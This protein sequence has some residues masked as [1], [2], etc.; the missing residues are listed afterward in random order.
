[1]DS[2]FKEIY[3]DKEHRFSLRVDLLTNKYYL[4]IQNNY[5]EFDYLEYYYVDERLIK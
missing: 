5:S 4:E 2:R 3:A 1:M